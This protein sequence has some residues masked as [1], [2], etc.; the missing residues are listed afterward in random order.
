MLQRAICVR[1]R[2]RHL[3]RRGQRDELVGGVVRDLL[4]TRDAIEL[5]ARDVVA[6]G[7]RLEEGE[8]DESL[9]DIGHARRAQVAAEQLVGQPLELLHLAPVGRGL[10]LDAHE[11]RFIAAAFHGRDLRI[12]KTAIGGHGGDGEETVPRR[13]RSLLQLQ[14]LFKLSSSVVVPVLGDV[15]K[16]EIRARHGLAG[17]ETHGFL[18]LGDRLFEH[19]AI[20]IERAEV[21][22]RGVVVRVGRQQQAVG[23]DR[24]GLIAR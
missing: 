7:H 3:E 11:V 12:R 24:L 2:E 1:L 22:V 16:P 14:D 9:A 19:V 18:E 5:R 10:R 23:F 20:A 8:R 4:E 13:D 17:R 15:G 6:P 21:G